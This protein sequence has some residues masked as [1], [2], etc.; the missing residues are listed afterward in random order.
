MICVIVDSVNI[1][2]H[3]TARTLPALKGWQTRRDA[4]SCISSI[5]RHSR[6]GFPSPP[7]PAVSPP[8]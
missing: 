5:R 2:P 4:K 7:A 8:A 3:L 6:S 1:W